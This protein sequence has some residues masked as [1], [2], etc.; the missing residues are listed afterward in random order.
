MLIKMDVFKDIFNDFNRKSSV[1]A[2]RF[3][4]QL[5]TEQLPCDMSNITIENFAIL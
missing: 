1:V 4:K 5:F 2:L 3:S